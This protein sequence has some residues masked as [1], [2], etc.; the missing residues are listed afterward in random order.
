MS[1][2][3]QRDEFLVAFV[4][5]RVCQ[6]DQ[7]VHLAVADGRTMLRYAATLQRLAEA[8]CNGDW[9]ADNGERRTVVCLGCEGGWAPVAMM[10]APELAKAEGT[11]T[12]TKYCPDCRTAFRV[13]RLA[14][15]YGYLARVG[16]DP[17]GYVVQLVPLGTSHEDAES[18]RVRGIGVPA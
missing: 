1:K 12:N 7:P 3:S 9:P 17:R 10:R 15:Q 13:K 18:G 4:R 16:G 2:A 5:D 8:Q 11:G 14:A 6:G